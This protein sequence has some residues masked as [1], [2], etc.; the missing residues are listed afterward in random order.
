[1][2]KL[3][4]LLFLVSTFACSGQTNRTIFINTS[5]EEQIVNY[6]PVNSG[7]T[8]E[9][10]KNALKLL[11][12]TKKRIEKN[13]N[14]FDV[15]DYWNLLVILNE[16]NETENNLIV[17][18]EKLNTA[19]GNCD[20]LTSFQKTFKSFPFLIEQKL[21]NAA[22][23][24]FGKTTPAFNLDNYIEVNNLDKSLVALINTIGIND[25]KYRT[26]DTKQKEQRKLDSLNQNSIDSLYIK[27]KQYLG[28]TLVGIKFQNVM[29]QVIQHSTLSY[30]EKYL[31]VIQKAVDKEEI[32][33]GS[34]KYLLDRIASEKTGVQYFGSQLNVPFANKKVIENIKKEYKI[35]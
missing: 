25:Q 23:I 17:A 30:M 14:K 22:N 34:L 12:E 33:Q 32:K 2:I 8:E 3:V 7:L 29:W 1:M 15:A 4:N 26:D 35:E 20:Y 9:K 27:Y 11:K 18:F 5:Y 13:N 28:K 19:D 10:Y 31:S 24:C 16:L 21:T 6:T